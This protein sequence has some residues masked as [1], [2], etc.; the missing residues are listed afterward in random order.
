MS[1]P[2][3]FPLVAGEKC[4]CERGCMDSRVPVFSSLRY[5]PQREWL[6]HLEILFLVCG[7]GHEPKTHKL[8]KTSAELQPQPFHSEKGCQ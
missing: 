5:T 1:V 3:C 6:E 8:G 2:L 7:C 4:C